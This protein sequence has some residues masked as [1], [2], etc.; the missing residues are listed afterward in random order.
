MWHKGITEVALWN[1]LTVCVAETL[2]FQNING[3][4]EMLSIFGD[5]MSFKREFP[6]FEPK[7]QTESIR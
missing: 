7:E 3:Y 2:G 5:F 1:V 6:I 4:F